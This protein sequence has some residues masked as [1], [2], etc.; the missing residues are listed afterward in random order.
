MVPK[1]EKHHICSYI[2]HLV[3]DKPINIKDIQLQGIHSLSVNALQN[4]NVNKVAV[5]IRN[6]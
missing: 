5:L 3:S 4:V 2:R 6:S 1:R